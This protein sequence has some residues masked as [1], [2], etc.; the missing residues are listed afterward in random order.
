MEYSIDELILKGAV[1]IAS[2]HE[3]TGEILYTITDKLREVLPA[4]HTE[5]MN[6][7][8][9]KVMYFWGL[10]LLEFDDITKENPSIELTPK[11]SDPEE[12]DK[13]PPEKLIEF[14]M[15]INAFRIN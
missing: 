7:I 9:A 14:E 13:L 2:V 3:N 15:L 6:S 4:M 8:H 5:F 10:G 12:L 1:E 11:A